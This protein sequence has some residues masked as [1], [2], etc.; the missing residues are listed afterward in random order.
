MSYCD[1]D[2]P[3]EGACKRRR[4]LWLGAGLGMFAM[5]AWLVGIIAPGS[6]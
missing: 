4:T 3:N 2:D 1:G 6:P 5:L